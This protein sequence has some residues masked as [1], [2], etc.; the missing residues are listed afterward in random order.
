MAGPRAPLAKDLAWR[1]EA[2]AFDVFSFVFRLLPVDWVSNAGG[3]LFRWL[4]P[5]TPSHRIAERNIRLAFPELSDEARARLLRDQWEGLGRTFFEFPVTDRLLPSTGRVEVVGRERLVEIARSGKAAILISGHFAN[6][7]VMA[8]AIV[9]AGVPCRV[10]YRAANNP[11]VDRRIIA[12]RARYG[13]KLFAPKGGQGSRDL[14]ETLS[15]G[16]SVAFLNDQKFNGGVA[17]PFFGRI[18]H[19]AGAPTRM[20]LRFGAVLQ[21]MS[22]QRLGGARFRVVVHEPIRLDRTGDRDR[23]LQAGVEKVNAFVE[24]RV[25]E[26][27]AE[28]FWVHK[29]W[30]REAYDEL[31][32]KGY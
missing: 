7:E 14:L 23:D 30:P 11:Y 25:R 9:D 13:V 15:G 2:L 1:L 5:V 19:T 10:T 4:G 29:R 28:W 8:G 12:G 3:W 17:A 21:P 26:R 32:A 22:V 18:V 6:W 16:E 24:A 20:A 27:P 31:A